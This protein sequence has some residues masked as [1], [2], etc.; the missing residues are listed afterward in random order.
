MALMMPGGT[1]ESLWGATVMDGQQ[2]LDVFLQA[3]LGAAIRFWPV[4]AL[5]AALFALKVLLSRVAARTRRRAALQPRPTN[6]PPESPLER[7]FL[8]LVG[9]AGLERPDPQ[10]LVPAGGHEYRV[11]F[12]YPR[13]KLAI[14]LDGRYHQQPDRR[15]WDEQRDARLTELGWTTVRLHDRD[16]EGTPQSVVT[17]LTEA[18]VT[19]RS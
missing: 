13:L 2:I 12:A 16:V 3:F 19:P 15:V 5:F 1:F 9:E 11:D 18:G 6:R 17:K 7:R 8:E 4:W 10:Y 14:E